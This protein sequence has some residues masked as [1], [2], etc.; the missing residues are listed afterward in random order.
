MT[1]D[2][3]NIEEVNAEMT[4]DEAE[5][6]VAQATGQV[7]IDTE[8]VRQKIIQAKTEDKS[9]LIER[10]AEI[11]LVWL[12]MLG[13]QHGVFHGTGGV[14]KSMTVDTAVE[15][16]DARVFS[17]LLRKSMP[18]EE[19]FGPLSLKGLENDEF[20][21]II[22]GR[23]ADAHI[24]FWDEIYKANAIALNAGLKVINERIFINNAI[25]LNVPLWSLFGA[26]NE[27]PT[28]PE[29]MAFRDRFAWHKEVRPVQTDDGFKA[30]IG[31]AL[32]R[33]KG[34]VT[35]VTRITAA[36]IEAAQAEVK[37]ITVPSNVMNNLATMKRRAEGEFQL[38][39][40]ARRY[41]AC[42]YLCMAQAWLNG[43]QHVIEDDLTLYQHS[44]WT[45]P[46]DFPKA[47]E[48]T[49]DYAGKV[50]RVTAKLRESYEPYRNDLTTLKS[51]IPTDGAQI[52]PELAGRLAAVQMNLKNV[53]MQVTK[54][55]EDAKSDG[56]DTS[57]LD[58]LLGEVDADRRY[59]REDILG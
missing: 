45:D 28:D 17:V 15:H 32:G 13:R 48:V 58:A 4:K 42:L 49:L 23:T 53:S 43:R 6:Q 33:G 59:I 14:A 19:M 38:F 39:I 5:T 50:A 51:E 35:G 57:E 1:P 27:L 24:A 20:R 46:E 18:F 11:D 31:G 21:Y 56:R 52:T 41:I 36:E 12:S 30:V 2:T 26:S 40:S 34:L 25:S 3:A 44:L 7:V 54:Q 47:Y 22:T 8:A 37:Q 55:I 16:I 9:K 10:D 29:L